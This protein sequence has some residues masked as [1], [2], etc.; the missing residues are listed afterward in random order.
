MKEYKEVQII[1]HALMRYIERSEATDK[2]IEEEK[3]LIQDYTERAERLKQRYG[4]KE[5]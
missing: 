4:I 5:R 3:R 2:E 1:K